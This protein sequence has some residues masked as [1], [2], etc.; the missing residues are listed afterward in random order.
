MGVAL[1]VIMILIT[2][3]VAWRKRTAPLKNPPLPT[4]TVISNLLNSSGGVAPESMLG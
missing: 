4:S 2:A 3:M 1:L